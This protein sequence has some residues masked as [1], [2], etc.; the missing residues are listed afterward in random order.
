MT[1]TTY[2]S[3][4]TDLFTFFTNILLMSS[5]PNASSADSED[6]DAWEDALEDDFSDDDDD[7]SDDDSDELVPS[8]PD[9]LVTGD[10]DDD[11]KDTDDDDLD[12]GAFDDD[13]E[14]DYMDFVEEYDEL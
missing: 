12:L 7:I 11:E 6:S 8:T 3:A 14:E 5:D 13:E 1:Y 4:I 9:V 10:D 2:F